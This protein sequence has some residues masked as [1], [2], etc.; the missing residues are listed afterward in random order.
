M[1]YVFP[2]DWQD[3]SI[4]GATSVKLYVAAVSALL[5]CTSERGHVSRG[6]EVGSLAWH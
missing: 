3:A 4:A 5:L 1:Q 2:P 6:H